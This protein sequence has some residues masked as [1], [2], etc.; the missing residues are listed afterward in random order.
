MTTGKVR[1]SAI[2]QTAIKARRQFLIV[3]NER[4]LIG[5]TMTM[6]LLTWF[7]FGITMKGIFV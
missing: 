7:R 3:Q 1:I 2:I 5:C 6:Y 4:D